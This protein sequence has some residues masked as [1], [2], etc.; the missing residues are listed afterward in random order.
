MR[1]QARRMAL[2]RTHYE[3]E[4]LRS[5]A[6]EAETDARVCEDGIQPFGE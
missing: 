4:R 1:G 3:K 5:E 6:V 2:G